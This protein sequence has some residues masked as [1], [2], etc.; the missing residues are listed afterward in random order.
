MLT[1]T[2]RFEPPTPEIGVCGVLPVRNSYLESESTYVRRAYG[3]PSRTDEQPTALQNLTTM[4]ATYS[5]KPIPPA[6]TPSVWAAFVVPL[7]LLGLFLVLTY[8]LY[9]LAIAGAFVGA[10]LL[11]RGLTV[12]VTRSRDRVREIPLPGVGTVRFRISP[13]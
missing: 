13:R 8:P 3:Q 2:H 10:K 1:L 11:Q 5:P 9:A 4:Y 6:D 7:L 12:L